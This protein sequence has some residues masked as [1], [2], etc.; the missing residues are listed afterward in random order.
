LGSI[1]S[2]FRLNPDKVHRCDC[3]YDFETKS[4]KTPSVESFDNTTCERKAKKGVSWTLIGAI[5]FGLLR[6]IWSSISS[7]AYIVVSSNNIEE[8]SVL[9]QIIMATIGGAIFGALIGGLLIGP[10][11]RAVKKRKAKI[12]ITSQVSVK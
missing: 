1:I 9:E 5:C 11:I 12:S 6:L 3:G 10:I 2:A 8:H 7:K 4:V